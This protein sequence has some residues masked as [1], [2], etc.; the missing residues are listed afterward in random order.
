MSRSL[1]YTFQVLVVVTMLVPTA[2]GFLSDWFH[3][4]G[5]ADVLIEGGIPVPQP[6][7]TD[8]GAT[9]ALL[10]TQQATI[11]ITDCGPPLADSQL[12]SAQI[13]NYVHTAIKII[14]DVTT[15]PQDPIISVGLASVQL[16]AGACAELYQLDMAVY[17]VFASSK[18]AGSA[19]YDFEE[20]GRFGLAF[21]AIFTLA[22][23]G[24]LMGRTVAVTGPPLAVDFVQGP[25][26]QPFEDPGAV[27]QPYDQEQVPE[28]SLAF[29]GY[30]ADAYPYGGAKVGKES[31]GKKSKHKKGK[32]SWLSSS[33][34]QQTNRG[35]SIIM[36]GGVMYVCAATVI[37]L[38]GYRMWKG[39]T[40]DEIP[41]GRANSKLMTWMMSEHAR[42]EGIPY[43]QQPIIVTGDQEKFASYQAEPN[44]ID[45]YQ[46]I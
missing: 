33:D 26:G 35:T 28:D 15:L 18:E 7:D 30:G 46:Q 8:P 2:E 13:Q 39:S 6:I 19:K 27:F 1:W 38:V 25:A 23:H 14:F 36:I 42:I 3:P 16:G 37:A 40:Y 31:K 22:V 10:L 29:G 44:A 41:E 4:S 21:K 32:Y 43:Q 45:G 20:H 11:N 9:S 17:I 24:S 5:A 12:T 34:Q